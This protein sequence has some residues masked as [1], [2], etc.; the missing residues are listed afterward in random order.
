MVTIGSSSNLELYDFEQSQHIS[1]TLDSMENSF[2]K[3]RCVAL[4]YPLTEV[5]ENE[6]SYSMTPTLDL[7]STNFLADNTQFL[8]Q[9]TTVEFNISGNEN[10]TELC[11]DDDDGNGISTRW[12]EGNFPLSTTDWNYITMPSLKTGDQSRTCSLPKSDH[13]SNGGT[14]LVLENLDSETRDEVMDVLFR[15]K[16]RIHFRIE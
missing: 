5:N 13:S 9:A 7:E 15:D 8:P 1:T 2:Q 3:R 12:Y 11:I 16:R 14:T 4:S 10:S 6:D